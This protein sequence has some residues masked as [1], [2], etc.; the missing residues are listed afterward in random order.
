MVHRSSSAALLSG[1]IPA[2]TAASWKLL[3]ADVIEIWEVS[4]ERR[5]WPL[6]SE[7]SDLVSFSISLKLKKEAHYT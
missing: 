5:E 2:A 3:P 6:C 7:L 1:D 4:D